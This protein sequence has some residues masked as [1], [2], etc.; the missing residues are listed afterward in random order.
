M[1][2]I[3]IELA[4][5]LPLV[6]WVLYALRKSGNNPDAVID[7]PERLPEERRGASAPQAP[8]GPSPE[9]DPTRQ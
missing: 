1:W 3:F 5:A 6:L 8:S 4:I 9:S 2:A 7:S